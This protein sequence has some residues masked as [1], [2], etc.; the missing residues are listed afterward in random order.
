[1]AASFDGGP[2]DRVRTWASGIAGSP[3]VEVASVTGGI[4]ATKWVL[5]LLDGRPLVVRWSD[6]HVWGEIGREH[7][8]REAWACRLLAGTGVSAPA[9]LA[10]DLDGSSTGGSANLLT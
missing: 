5:H 10:S 3:V 8:K 6:P 4:T 9:L 7:V 2:P 1:M